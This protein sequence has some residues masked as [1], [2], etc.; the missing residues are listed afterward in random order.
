MRFRLADFKR[1]SNRSVPFSTLSTLARK[2]REFFDEG[3]VCSGC[4]TKIR[5]YSFRSSKTLS[6]EQCYIVCRICETTFHFL[7]YMDAAGAT[8]CDGAFYRWP[9]GSRETHAVAPC[10]KCKEQ[11]AC[12]I[13]LD[14]VRRPFADD[15][16]VR[17]W[18]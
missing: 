18:M 2:I 10:P 11:E 6:M 15:E 8:K 13:V 7:C 4:N 9:R 5:P 3:S 16:V 14:G 12:H 1:A 17:A